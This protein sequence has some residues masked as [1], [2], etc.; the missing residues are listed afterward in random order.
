MLADDTGASAVWAAQR[1]PDD[2][3]TA[4]AN[5]FVIGE[6]DLNDPTNFMASGEIQFSSVIIRPLKSNEVYKN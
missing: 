2:H 1:V 6:I 3:I 4:V 5:Q